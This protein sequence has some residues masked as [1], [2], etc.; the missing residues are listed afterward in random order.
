MRRRRR[1][2]IAILLVLVILAAAGGFAFGG[3]RS[4]LD[5]L[6]AAQIESVLSEQM[7]QAVLTCLA[8]DGGAYDSY[9]LLERDVNGE[10]TALQTNVL[11]VN[12]LRAEVVRSVRETVSQGTEISV[13]V[14]LGNLFLPALFS[15]EGPMVPVHLMSVNALHAEFE[16]EFQQAGINQTLH[17]IVIRT[18]VACT[19]LVLGRTVPIEVTTDVVAAET[20]LMGSVPGTYINID[21]I[22]NQ[23]G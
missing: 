2:A 15:G 9:V 20:V 13:Q 1:R 7:N 22:D 12:R 21:K 11:R 23:G 16:N 19:A 17:R 3:T 14:P 6:A 8:A 18:T 4:V 10:L 5:E